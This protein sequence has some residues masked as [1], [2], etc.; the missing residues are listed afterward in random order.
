M[1]GA[2]VLTACAA[3]ALDLLNHAHPALMLASRR[4]AARQAL[5]VDDSKGLSCCEFIEGL[6]RLVRGGLAT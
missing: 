2:G 1:G 4:P 3:V 5:D 6:R